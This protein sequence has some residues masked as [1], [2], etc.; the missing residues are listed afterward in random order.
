[1]KVLLVNPPFYRLLGSRFK[2]VPLGLAYIAEAINRTEHK[3]WIYNADDCSAEGCSTKTIYDNSINANEILNNSQHPLWQEVVNTI[4][5]QEPDVVGWT[6]LASGVQP[7]ALLSK[8]LK[9]YRFNGKQWIGGPQV[10]LDRKS[11]QILKYIDW[12]CIGEGEEVCTAWLNEPMIQN[13]WSTSSSRIENIDAIPDKNCCI[14]CN[15]QSVNYIITA[16]GCPFTCAFCSSP[17]VWS[18]R[19]TFRSLDSIELEL[20]HL[21]NNLPVYFVD[22]TFTAIER[23]AKEIMLLAKENEITWL[24]D[25][26]ADRITTS[27]AKWMKDCG[28]GQAKIGVESGSSRIL[29]L[30]NK[31]ETKEQMVQAVSL[32]KENEIP[33]TCYLMAGFPGEK[34]RDLEETIEFTKELKADHYSL[35]VYSPYSDNWAESFHQSKRSLERCGYSKE[36]I[37]RFWNLA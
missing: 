12:F 17:E 21:N 24:C 8:L 5:S 9:Q 23:R 1:M 30:M 35:S 3:A 14:N 10:L 37:E 29:R 36:L 22:D 15:N 27:L 16:R 7:I 33:V 25:T 20:K 32:L 13:S 18:H 4:L 31:K 19:V 26:R 34:E 2:E 6:C 28:C 11:H